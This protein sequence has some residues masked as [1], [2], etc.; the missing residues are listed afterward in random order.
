MGTGTSLVSLG[1]PHSAK[2]YDSDV[3]EEGRRE[4]SH[5]LCHVPSTC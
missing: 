4:L 1:C 3:K 2:A 5:E